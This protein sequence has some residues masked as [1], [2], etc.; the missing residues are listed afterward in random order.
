L[1]KKEMNAKECAGLIH[2]DIQKG[3]IKGQ[4]YNYQDWLTFHDEVQLKKLGKI[5]TESPQYIIQ[6]G[7]ICHFLFSKSSSR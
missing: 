2:S 1:A 7:D 3:F 4:I 5:R 6:E